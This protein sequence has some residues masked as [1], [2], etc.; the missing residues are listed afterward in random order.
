MFI[1]VSTTDVR[2]CISL[3][4]VTH[5]HSLAHEYLCFALYGLMSCHRAQG[6]RD[7]ACFFRSSALEIVSSTIALLL[8]IF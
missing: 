2:V 4:T 5:I 6:S 8:Q 7:F 3:L 1:M